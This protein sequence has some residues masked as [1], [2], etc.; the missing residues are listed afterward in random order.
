MAHSI[1]RHKTD[2][3]ERST[4]SDESQDTQSTA[5]TTLYSNFSI[6]RAD[7]D[8]S[9]KQ[10]FD[11]SPCTN[12]CARSSTE[13]YSSTVESFE[14]LTDEP[15]TD[16]PSDDALESRAPSGGCA[17]LRPSTPADFAHFFPSLSRLCIR[18]DDTTPDGNMNLRVDIERRRGTIQLFHLK[19][20]DLRQREFSLRRYERA[21][22]REVCHSARKPAPRAPSR[23]ARSRSPGRARP[24]PTTPA[25]R[26]DSGYGSGDEHEPSY[27]SP[28][29]VQPPPPPSDTVKLEFA[30][31]AQVE[32]KPRGA[33]AATRYEFEYW[34]SRYAW[35]RVERRSEVEYH[36]F[37]EGKAEQVPVAHIVPELRSPEQVR[38]EERKGGW[39]PPCSMWIEERGVL[40]AESDVADVI[41]ATGLIALVDDTIKRRFHPQS[42]PS[43]SPHLSAK[44]HPHSSFKLDF[45]PKALVEHMFKRRDSVP[46]AASPSRFASGGG[47]R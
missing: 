30:N 39:V 38:E 24:P 26:Q 6:P 42:R 11:L 12:F 40:K 2:I 13:T 3:S 14:E 16:N 9:E 21:S 44:A 19:M 27:F 28:H 41:V 34:G 35:R 10:H 4:A 47:A 22:G 45:G 23:P 46:E 33:K 29:A 32:V 20:N 5:P 25:Q 1:R 8:Y 17:S 31:Y 43:P 7:L 15:D 18:H 37:R 36:L